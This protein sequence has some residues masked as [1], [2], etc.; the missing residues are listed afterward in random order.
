MTTNLIQIVPVLPTSDM[1]RDAE[2]YEKFTGF[3]SVWHDDMYGIFRRGEHEIHLQWHADT[4]DDPLLGGSVIRIFVDEI[5]PIFEEFVE[6][7]TV[8]T[9]KL[10]LGTAWGTNEFGFYDLNNNAIFIVQDA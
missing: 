6:R 8:G 2:W 5:R 4:E 10:L 9:E 3:K 1:T 7:G